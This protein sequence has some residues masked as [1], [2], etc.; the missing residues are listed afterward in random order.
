MFMVNLFGFRSTSPKALAAA[1][2]PI[3]PENDAWLDWAVA[4]ADI[5]IAAWGNHGQLLSRAESVASRYK[6]RLKT[7]ALTKSGMPG[8]PLYI[9]SDVCPSAF[10]S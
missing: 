4:Q 8:H 9:R 7:L 3:G 2:D 6:G 10:D 5:V 1:A